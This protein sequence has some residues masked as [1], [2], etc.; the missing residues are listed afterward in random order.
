MI[1]L[2]PKVQELLALPAVSQIGMVMRDLQKAVD[3]HTQVLKIGPFKIFEPLYTDQ[4]YRGKPGNFL[5]R[6]AIASIGPIDIEFIQPLS[7]ETV[8]AEFLKAH[9]EG[10]H[11]VGFVIER[12]DERIGALKKIGIE[13]VQSGKRPGVAWAYIDT[14]SL[15]GYMIELIERT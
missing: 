10:L 1:P 4:T 9:R 5:S 2:D 14:E 6:L 8:Y 12:L 15:A 3:F 11:H 7:G 13:V